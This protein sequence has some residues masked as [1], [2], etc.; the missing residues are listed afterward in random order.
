MTRHVVRS[1]GDEEY[2]HTFGEERFFEN[3]HFEDQG[4]TKLISGIM[5]GR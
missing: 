3:I 2:A 1:L 4:D 5:L